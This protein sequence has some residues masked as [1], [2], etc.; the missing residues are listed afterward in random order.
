[1]SDVF[2][3]C[4]GGSRSLF[5]EYCGFCLTS[6]FFSGDYSKAE[7]LKAL[8]RRTVA[9]VEFLQARWLTCHSVSKH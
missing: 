9:K 2:D 4:G 7:T 8:Q 5:L 3:E 1:V 6:L